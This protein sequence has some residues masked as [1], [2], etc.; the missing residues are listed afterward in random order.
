MTDIL[1]R[2][3]IFGIAS[4]LCGQAL[5]SPAT[6]AE[7]SPDHREWVAGCLKRMLTIQQGMTRVRL[8]E[9]FITEGGLVFSAL[10]QRFV[11][12]DCPFF[13]VE[14]KFNRAPHASAGQFEELNSDVVASISQPYLQFTIA[15]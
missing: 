12:R 13:K 14:V 3:T 9:V 7:C 2:Q 8:M 10:Q 15:D 4:G 6:D 5:A 1:R 11:S